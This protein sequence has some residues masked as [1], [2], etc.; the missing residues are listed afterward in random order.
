MEV[1]ILDVE[2]ADWN[3]HYRKVR[4]SIDYENYTNYDKKNPYLKRLIKF[5]N[6]KLRSLEFGSGKGSLSLI[7]KRNY[8]E[9]DIHLLDLESD[10]IEFSKGLFQHFNLKAEFYEHD[11]MKLPFP[12]EYFDFIHGNTVLEHVPETKKAVTEL[13]RVLKKGGH[14]MVTVP[15]SH[16]RFDGHDLYHS[17]N[18]FNYF[19]RTFYPKELEE[20]FVHNSCEIIDRFGTG[21]VYHYPSYLPRYIMEKIRQRKNSFKSKSKNIESTNNS[22]QKK[23]NTDSIFTSKEKTLYKSTF[24]LGD[25]IW[26]PIQ[27]KINTFTSRNELFP[28]SW[29]IIIGIVAKKV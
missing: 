10:A 19:S 25:R 11:F 4:N 22:K 3:T 17:I 16:R 5:G 24:L 6:K 29:W 23:I 15:N 20:F 27:K 21:C 26:D 28:Y 8:P 12:D 7:L 2:K 9:I 13:C 1:K 14:I 18:R